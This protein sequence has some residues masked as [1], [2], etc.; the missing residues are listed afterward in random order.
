MNNKNPIEIKLNN[1]IHYFKLGDYNNALNHLKLLKI[2][3]KHF[4]IHWYLGHT[5]FKGPNRAQ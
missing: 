3:S 5:Y 2:E 1:A 4:L